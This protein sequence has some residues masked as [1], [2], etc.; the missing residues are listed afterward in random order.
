MLFLCCDCSPGALILISYADRFQQGRKI[1]NQQNSQQEVWRQNQISRQSGPGEGS[2]RKEFP[3]Q[4]ST[5][6]GQLQSGG[7]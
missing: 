7:S 5:R 4:D 6:Q 1:L 2:R 3:N